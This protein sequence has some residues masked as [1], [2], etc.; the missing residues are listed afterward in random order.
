MQT[1]RKICIFMDGT[2]NDHDSQTHIRHLYELVSGRNQPGI[3]CY[4]DP[5]VGAEVYKGT[6]AVGGAGFTTNIK[7]SYAFLTSVYQPKDQIYIFG[8]SRGARQ[9]QVLSD[10]IARC[11]IP[12]YLDIKNRSTYEDCY[13]T[14]ADIV[15]DYKKQWATANRKERKKS[16]QN[17]FTMNPLNVK[18]PQFDTTGRFT[19]NINFLGMW[20]NVESL[21]NNV[22]RQGLVYRKTRKPV[23]YQ[24]HKVYPYVISS[25]VVKSYHA[26]ALDE[27]RGLYE[28]IPWIVP[29]GHQGIVE[30][31][32]FPGTHGD[33][34][35]SYQSSEVLAGVSFNWM[36]S[37]LDR[38]GLLPQQ[39]YRVRASATALSVDSG[40]FKVAGV[41]L[42][43]L[44]LKRV[45]RPAFWGKFWKH[46]WQRKPKLHISALQRIRAKQVPQKPGDGL[47]AQNHPYRPNI[48]FQRKPEE[49]AQPKV[50][51]IHCNASAEEITKWLRKNADIVK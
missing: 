12:K 21:A 28:V 5:G 40:Q 13:K 8:Y 6:G 47:D 20:D 37:K 10:V 14:T 42:N 15:S 11:G 36:L 31:V 26:M 51:Y 23:P 35:G 44:R 24:P 3:I 39:G 7:Q 9:A 41:F 16:Q 33:V 19:P 25:K 30:R 50:P 43:K 48:F 34:G 22:L 27:S 29:T 2:A 45:R 38:T 1:G 18:P 49:P 32:W 17:N 46:D 4:Y